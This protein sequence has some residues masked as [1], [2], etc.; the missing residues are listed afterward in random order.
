[1]QEEGGWRGTA[2][3][4]VCKKR[5]REVEGDIVRNRRRN[6]DFTPRQVRPETRNS[7]D[8][9]TRGSARPPAACPTRSA[10]PPCDWRARPLCGSRGG[11]AL[12]TGLRASRTRACTRRAP[13]P[14]AA[15][16]VLPTPRCQQALLSCVG[17]C[18][19]RARARC[20]TSG[21]LRQ[22]RGL[23]Q[24]ARCRDEVCDKGGNSGLQP[25]LSRTLSRGIRRNLFY[26]FRSLLIVGDARDFLRSV[27]MITSPSTRQGD[28]RC[29]TVPDLVRAIFAFADSS[30][31]RGERVVEAIIC[32]C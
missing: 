25:R 18:A 5:A 16:P 4:C 24:G 30:I 10:R 15:C 29:T 28:T 2:R 7:I 19:R 8:C 32:P 20:A 1:M 9:R 31:D 17:C 21:L 27:G 12:R 22:A 14:P 6:C 13:P 26:L 3:P 23:R 11:A